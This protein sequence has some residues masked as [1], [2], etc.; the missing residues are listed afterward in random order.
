MLHCRRNRP[1]EGIA[2]KMQASPYRIPD[3]FY[4]KIG[5]VSEISGLPSHVLRFWESEFPKIKPKRTPS[6][7]RLYTQKDVRLILDIKHLLHEE[8]FTIKGARKYIS[9]KGSKKQ[10]VPAEFIAELKTELKII[11]NLL[12]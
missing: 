4:F 8:K 9:A 12:D 2:H 6:G 3:K 11:R 7:Q 1:A 5:E 10:K